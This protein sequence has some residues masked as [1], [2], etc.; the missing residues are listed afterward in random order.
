M[1]R[2]AIDQ[3]AAPGGVDAGEDLPTSPTGRISGARGCARLTTECPAA[4]GPQIVAHRRDRHGHRRGRQ[5]LRRPH[6]ISRGHRCLVHLGHSDRS[7]PSVVLRAGCPKRAGGSPNNPVVRRRHRLG[8]LGI[9]CAKARPPSGWHAVAVTVRSSAPEC[10]RRERPHTLF[11]RP[12]SPTT[13]A[14]TVTPGTPRCPKSSTDLSGCERREHA[15]AGDHFVPDAGSP[16]VIQ[17]L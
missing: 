10:W 2:A 15:D 7:C 9:H 5:R 1:F 16:R 17:C 12:P 8:G 13:R 14:A 4:G 6:A 11:R 3:V